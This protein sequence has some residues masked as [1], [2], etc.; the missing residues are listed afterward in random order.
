M[1]QF[2][3]KAVLFPLIIAG[4]LLFATGIV[5]IKKP[6]YSCFTGK[7]IRLG[8]K[9]EVVT[10]GS[11]HLYAYPI[12]HDCEPEDRFEPGKYYKCGYNNWCQN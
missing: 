2:G 12:R 8:E 9:V 10:L 7:R 5:Q 1:T 6:D 3:I 4:V 11:F